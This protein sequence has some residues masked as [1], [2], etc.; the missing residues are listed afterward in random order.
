MIYYVLDVEKGTFERV[1]G[2]LPCDTTNCAFP[3]SGLMTIQR[4]YHLDEL[5]A[6]RSAKPPIV[7]FSEVLRQIPCPSA[8]KGFV[9]PGDGFCHH[10]DLPDPE[11]RTE[12]PASAPPALPSY[13]T[14]AD[15]RILNEAFMEKINWEA[16]D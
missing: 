6:S 3:L 15:L 16:E 8:R 4:R 2:P 7:A 9:C 12:R 14:A 10:L 13:F 1:T 11:P 5:F